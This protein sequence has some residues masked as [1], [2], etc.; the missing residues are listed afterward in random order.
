MSKVGYPKRFENEEDMRSSAEVLYD[1]GGPVDI[2]LSNVVVRRSD[3]DD[4]HALEQAI[5]PQTQD[6]LDLLYNYPRLIQRVEA[7]YLSVTIVDA[8]NRVIGMAVFEDYPQGL[9]GMYDFFHENCWEQWLSNAF[10]IRGEYEIRP[11]NSLWLV[12]F[13]LGKR[14]EY[15]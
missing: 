5:D 7:C 15:R 2:D 6:Q 14:S 9:E 8:Q 3:G 11:F 1:A 10:H 4:C 13:H 12:Y